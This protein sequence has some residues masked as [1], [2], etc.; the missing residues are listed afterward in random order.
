MFTFETKRLA[1]NKMPGA[2]GRAEPQVSLISKFTSFANSISWPD[3]KW[4][5]FLR[6]TSIHDHGSSFLDAWFTAAIFLPDIVF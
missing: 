4:K 3:M 6:L 5:E 2:V 1:H